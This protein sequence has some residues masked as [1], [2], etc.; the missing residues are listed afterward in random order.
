MPCTYI[1][2]GRFAFNS[3]LFHDTAPYVKRTLHSIRDAHVLGFVQRLHKLELQFAE[4]V[5]ETR[6]AIPKHLL[7]EMMDYA[8]FHLTTILSPAHTK[9]SRIESMREW[10]NMSGTVSFFI[11]NITKYMSW[12][13]YGLML[14]LV[15]VYLSD[16]KKLVKMWCRYRESVKELFAA[17]NHFAVQY[18][19]AVDFGLAKC[20]TSKIMILKVVREDYTM[21]DLFFFHEAIPKALR[22]G[23]YRFY[24]CRVDRGCLELTYSIPDTIYSML[25]PL[26]SEQCHSLA[27]IGIYKLTCEEYIYEMDRVRCSL[28]ML[29]K[30]L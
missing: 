19:G 11:M 16:N 23:D 29:Q 14:R 10:I 6:D 18:G 8:S 2:I 30:F 26:T 5:Y 1:F 9:Y 4:A 3:I 22:V 15:K 27:E 25:F 24:L 28:L 21:N 17:D 12:F 13:N 20:I 7:P